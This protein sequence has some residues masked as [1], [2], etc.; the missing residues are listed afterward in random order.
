MVSVVLREIDGQELLHP[1]PKELCPKPELC[2][3]VSRAQLLLWSVIASLIALETM[4]IYR[5][6]GKA[7]ADMEPSIVSSPGLSAMLTCQ[8]LSCMIGLQVVT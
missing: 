1:K 6:D 4:F 5:V 3:T 2:A 7:L 8:T